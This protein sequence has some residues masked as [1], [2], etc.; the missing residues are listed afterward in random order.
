MKIRPAVPAD[1]K[2][3]IILDHNFATTRVWQMNRRDENG[4]LQVDFHSVRLPREMRVRYPRDPNGL[5][6][7]WR[8]WDAFVVAD[9]QGYIQG[10]AGLTIDSAEQRGWISDLVV[11]RPYRRNGVGSA[12]LRQVVQWASNQELCQITLEMQSK[13]HPAI[14]F[15]L[16]HGFK[17]CGYNESHYS[18]RDIA[19]FFVLRLG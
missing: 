14:N 6:N 18:N 3:C 13:N 15:C 8:H 5:W 1:L 10:Y 19:L 17:F 12:L 7:K 11:G 2:Q 16:K 4:A 9:V